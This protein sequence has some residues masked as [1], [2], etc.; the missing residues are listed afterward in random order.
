M[1]ADAD[2]P[3]PVEDDEDERDAALRLAERL[4]ELLRGSTS[5]PAF[6]RPA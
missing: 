5:A 4:T 3:P 1:N 2:A 6:P